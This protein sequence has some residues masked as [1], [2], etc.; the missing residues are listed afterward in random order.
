[1]FNAILRV[2]TQHLKKIFLTDF[3]HSQGNG[4]LLRLM[5]SASFSVY[6]VY[7]I[8]SGDVSS[9]YF[10]RELPLGL[11]EAGWVATAEHRC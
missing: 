11:P 7:I 1:M 6:L 3:S 4:R 10:W 2:D 9:G 5:K 8:C